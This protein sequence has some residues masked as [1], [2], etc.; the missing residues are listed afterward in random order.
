M[1]ATNLNKYGYRIRTRSG[2]T[3][4]NLVIQG[5]DEPEAQ[6]K[7]MRMYPGCMV[8]ETR[9]IRP[10]CNTNVCSSFEDVVDVLA[11]DR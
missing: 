11:A 4:D 1:L 10:A 9:D 6:Q 2:V 3:V 5:R 8:I 7:L